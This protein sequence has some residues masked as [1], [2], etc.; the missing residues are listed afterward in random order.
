MLTSLWPKQVTVELTVKVRSSSAQLWWVGPET[1]HAECM[2]IG[3]GEN[4][5]PSLQATTVIL[6]VNSSFLLF[7][8]SLAY[9]QRT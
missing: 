2:E 9:K 3:K 7:G 1:L 4:L 8:V 5:G 6:L